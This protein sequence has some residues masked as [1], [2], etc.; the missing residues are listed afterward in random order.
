MLMLWRVANL[1]DRG[2]SSKGINSDVKV[3]VT[4]KTRDVTRLGREIMGGNGILMDNYV[5]KALNDIEGL[6]TGEGTNE[7][8]ALVSGRDLTG[9]SAFTVPYK[10]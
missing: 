8:C 3:Y 6:I 5:M 10:K 7:I 2:V 9:I 4:E 1:E